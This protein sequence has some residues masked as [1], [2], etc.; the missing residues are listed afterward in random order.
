MQA[1]VVPALLDAAAGVRD[2]GGPVALVVHAGVVR[3]ALS[4]AL[5][6]PALGMA[7]EVDPLSLTSLR[8]LQDGGFSVRRVNGSLR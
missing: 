6:S 5:A 8:C 3:V 1:R 7:F 2:G 4:L